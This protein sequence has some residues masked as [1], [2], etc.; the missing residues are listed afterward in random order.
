VEGAISLAA[1]A[2]ADRD[3]RALFPMIDQRARN[4]LASLVK[5]RARAVDVIQKSY[6][7]EAREEALRALGDAREAADPPALFAQRCDDA[8]LDAFAERLSAPE[9]VEEQGQLVIVQTVRGK[10]LELFRGKDGR[11]GLVWN[12]QA[13]QRESSRAFA[14]LDLIQRNAALYEKQRALR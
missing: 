11:Y 2:V 14:E 7:A 12:T 5:A 3:S 9:R 4:A 1:Q 13:L 10:Q 6:P 8:C